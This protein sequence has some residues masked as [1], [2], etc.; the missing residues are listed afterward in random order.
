M[1]LLG[2][3]GASDSRNCCRKCLRTLCTFVSEGQ[4]VGVDIVE[5]D[6]VGA[7]GVS[8][9]E[10]QNGGGDAGVG[11]LEHAA[12]SPPP[13][14]L[15]SSMYRVDLRQFCS[16]D[17]YLAQRLVRVGRAEEHAV[18]HDYGGAAAG[19]SFELFLSW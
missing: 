11:L 19:S 4:A 17:E 7:A 5:P 18:G 12:R 2:V 13:S 16:L 10:K 9:G 1:R 8:L 15:Q 3:S 6:V 14:G